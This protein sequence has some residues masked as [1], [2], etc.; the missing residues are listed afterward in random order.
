MS[1]PTAARR[2]AIALGITLALSFIVIGVDRAALAWN[3][4]DSEARWLQWLGP[5]VNLRR[6]WPSFFW[7]LDPGKALS[8]LPFLLHVLLWLL[9]GWVGWILIVQ[10]RRPERVPLA[11]PG[12]FCSL[13][14]FGVAA[15]LAADARIVSRSGALPVRGAD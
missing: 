15:G 2:L 13:V 8:E 14:S 1:G 4:R 6:G 11:S 3:V 7:R 12:T 9:V 10:P 5:V